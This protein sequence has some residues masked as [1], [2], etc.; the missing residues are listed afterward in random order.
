MKKKKLSPGNKIISVKLTGDGD[1]TSK[2]IFE[3]ING[4]QKQKRSNVRSANFNAIEGQQYIL[5]MEI[6]GS[7]GQKYKV[8]ISSAK[9]AEYPTAEQTLDDGRDLINADIVA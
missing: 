6:I 5:E 9:K 2:L 1:F 4:D 7:S 3:S 8:S